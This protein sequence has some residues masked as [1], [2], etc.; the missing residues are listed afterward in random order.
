MKSSRLSDILTS[1]FKIGSL[2]KET[3]ALGQS[4]QH[5]GTI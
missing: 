5:L 2:E 3:L 4:S 1:F